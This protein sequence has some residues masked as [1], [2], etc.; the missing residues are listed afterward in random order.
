MIRLFRNYLLASFL[1]VVLLEVREYGGETIGYIALVLGIG[2][3]AA[4]VMGRRK[5]SANHASLSLSRT[6]FRGACSPAAETTQNAVLGLTTNYVFIGLAFTLVTL[7]LGLRGPEAAA[8]AVAGVL[9]ASAAHLSIINV[10]TGWVGNLVK[11]A[12]MNGGLAN[13]SDPATRARVIKRSTAISLAYLVLSLVALLS[14]LGD[15]AADPLWSLFVMLVVLA[16]PALSLRNAALYAATDRTRLAIA[17]LVSL[18]LELALTATL[19]GGFYATDSSIGLL[20]GIVLAYL[21]A[22]TVNPVRWYLFGRL[23]S[24]SVWAV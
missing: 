2:S 6:A 3:V 14:L 8:G 19:A 1:V 18:S 17:M 5:R 7:V 11:Y 21:M 23:G 9:G 15:G 22:A 24:A 13:V 20:G 16:L 4:A 12:S 10:G